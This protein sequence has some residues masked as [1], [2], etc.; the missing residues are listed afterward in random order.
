MICF[1]F[2]TTLAAT[3]FFSSDSDNHQH[4]NVGRDV[5]LPTLNIPH[6][7]SSSSLVPASSTGAFRVVL[8]SPCL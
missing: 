4:E 6:A 5:S 7:S 8:L 2:T 1:L 3:L